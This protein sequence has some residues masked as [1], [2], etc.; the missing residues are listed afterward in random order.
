MKAPK[1]CDYCF[2]L[3]KTDAYLEL[4]N[5]KTDSRAWFCSPTCLYHDIEEYLE[6]S[7]NNTQTDVA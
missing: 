3:L 1:G 4:V 6:D 2:G 5:H 7:A